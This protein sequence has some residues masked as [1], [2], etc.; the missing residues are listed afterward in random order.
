MQGVARA[1][2]LQL[3]NP[4]DSTRGG[5]AHPDDNDGVTWHGPTAENCDDDYED[6]DTSGTASGVVSGQLIYGANICSPDASPDVDYYVITVGSAG[7]KLIAE[8]LAD[9][10]GSPLDTV[11]TLYD[12]DGT[13][14]LAQNHDFNGAVSTD[15]RLEY[16]F[17][18]SGTY[19]V[20]VEDFFGFGEGIDHWYEMTIVVGDPSYTNCTS[21]DVPEAQCDAL[22]DLYNS[23]GG[24][25][26]YLRGGWMEFDTVCDWY[27][28]DCTGGNVTE[29]ELDGNNFGWPNSQFDL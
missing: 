17:S 21:V 5:E 12:T 22:V 2:P 11:V 7:D 4:T 27:G 16:T 28:V 14:Q 20:S 23:T 25:S 24:G 10:A 1:A 9:R 18:S 15:S 13:S 19:Y 29:V 8:T 6:N 3:N 26:W